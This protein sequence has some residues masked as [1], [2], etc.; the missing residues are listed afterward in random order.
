VNGNWTIIMDMDP[1]PI[2]YLTIDGDVYLGDR[3]TS[4]SADV[5]F[6]RAGSLNA[7]TASDPF[8]YTLTITLNGNKSD[9]SFVIDPIVAAN[10]YM[11]V[12]GEL[13]LYGIAPSTVWTT[14]TAKAAAG[15]TAMSVGSTSGW[16]VGDQLVIGPS[17]QSN[18]SEFVTITAVTSTS[19]S[20]TPALNYTHYGD[21]NPLT[22]SY[23][24]IDMRAAVGHITRNIQIVRGADPNTWGFR[25]LVY[26]FMDGDVPR[27]GSA[28]LNGVQFV[29][30]GQYDT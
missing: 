14:L 5:I 23:G 27:L 16:A 2:T 22:N 4:I 20:F 3:N 26:G 30:G 15:A 28:N 8:N 21:T 17:F 25:V 11:V 9:Q 18:Q 24:T 19:V 10:K 13:N 7:G 6:I 12:T 1:A 29:E